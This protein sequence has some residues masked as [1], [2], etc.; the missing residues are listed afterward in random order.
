ME[1]LEG[2]IERKHIVIT[3]TLTIKYQVLKSHALIDCRATGIAFRDQNYALN[4]Q[5]PSH[6][7][8]VFC[9]V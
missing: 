2:S 8:K 1:A 4:Q 9:F 7:I 6:N 3:C 5:L